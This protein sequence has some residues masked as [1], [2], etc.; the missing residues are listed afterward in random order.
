MVR[1]PKCTDSYDD[2]E[3]LY[4]ED[5]DYTGDSVKVLAKVRCCNCNNEFWVIETFVFKEGKNIF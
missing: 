3:I 1:C 2:Y 5:Y 4:I